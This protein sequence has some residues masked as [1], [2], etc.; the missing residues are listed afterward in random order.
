MSYKSLKD[1]PNIRP[2]KKKQPAQARV[3]S[4]PEQSEAP[5]SDKDL[6]KQAMHGVRPID[7][8]TRGRQINPAGSKVNPPD[9]AGPESRS[10]QQLLDLVQGKAEFEIAHTTE[11]VLGHVKGLTPQTFEKLKKGL[12]SPEAHIDLHGFTLDNARAAV[13]LFVREHYFAGRRCLLVVTGRGKNSPTGRS[14]LRDG[15][16]DWLTRDP[17]KRVVLAFCT[18]TPGHGGAGAVYVLLRKLKKD[19]GK[20][21]W[22]RFPLGEDF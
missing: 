16:Q 15:L 13:T 2:R 18:A 20:I 9:P 10:R 12:L 19:R 22:D 5:A 7:D 11:F 17:L 4:Q 3:P 14:L 6:F 8:N 21:L 1:L